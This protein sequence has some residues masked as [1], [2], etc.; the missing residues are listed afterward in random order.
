MRCNEVHTKYREF[1]N[2][3]ATFVLFHF[4]GMEHTIEFA[5][6]DCESLAV[7]LQYEQNFGQQ[8]LTPLG[9]HFLFL[10]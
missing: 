10:F 5:H 7:T 2:I 6:C 4:I 3:T 8:L 9:W 1:L